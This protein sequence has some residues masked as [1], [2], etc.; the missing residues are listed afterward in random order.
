MI[1]GANA[2]RQEQ[3]LRGVHGEPG[4]EDRGA[5]HQ[6]RMAQHFLDPRFLVGDAGNRR[7]FAAGDRRRHADLAHAQARAN[8]RRCPGREWRR[9]LRRSQTLLA[10]QSCTALAPSVIEPP[11]TVTMRSAHRRRA[12][13]L[14]AAMTAARGVC[15]GIASKMATQRA[16]SARRI[17]SI[18]SVSRLSVPLT[19]RN[20]RTA[21]RRS[22]CSTI[23]SAA[24]RPNTTS[25]MAPNTT[26]PLCTRLSSPGQF[27]LAGGQVSGGN[28]GRHARRCRPHRR[29]SG[30]TRSVEP[31]IHTHDGGYGFRARCFRI[32]PE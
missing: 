11:P 14:A 31:G 17:F 2:G 26:R 5:R 7:E 8:G 21:F 19:I 15:A 25:S 1:D 20:A 27:G 28:S 12:P 13:G 22:I 3:P 23:A 6:Q 4:I 9:C 10:R 30:A 29:H 32:A 24:G 18:S 16:P